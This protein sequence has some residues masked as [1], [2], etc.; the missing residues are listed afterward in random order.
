MNKE[1]AK[2][3]GTAARQARKNLQLTQEDVA[4]RIDVSV[5]FYARIE[6]GTSLPSIL[7]FVRIVSALGVSADALLGQHYAATPVTANW[8]PSSTADNADVR[9]VVRRIRKAQ[10]STLRLVNLLL[11]ELERRTEEQRAK[12]TP[13]VSAA[14]SEKV[15][16]A[17]VAE[18]ATPVAENATPVATRAE[19]ESADESADKSAPAEA[20][21][22]IAASKAL[23]SNAPAPGMRSISSP[24]RVYAYGSTASA[25]NSGDAVTQ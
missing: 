19:E 15:S 12:A 17:P 3:I 23:E 8:M 22:L 14:P 1:L 5:E 21:E 7:T 18:N 11:K 16:P 25:K 6:R 24:R 20:T 13:T 9:R 10:P 2:M 4:E